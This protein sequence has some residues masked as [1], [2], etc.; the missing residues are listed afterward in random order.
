[1]NAEPHDPVSDA[2]PDRSVKPRAAARKRGGG[3]V[4]G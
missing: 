1:M 2:V 3:T 4:F